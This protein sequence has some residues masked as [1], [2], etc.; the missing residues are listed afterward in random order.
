MKAINVEWEKI[1]PEEL[2]HVLFK[3][4]IKDLIRNALQMP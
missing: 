1:I 4:N 2:F 3:P